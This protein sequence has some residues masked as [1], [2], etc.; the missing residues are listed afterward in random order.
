MQ[1]TVMIKENSLS[2]HECFALRMTIPINNVQVYLQ[3]NDVTTQRAPGLV[4][5]N[6]DFLLGSVLNAVS[7]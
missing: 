7:I 1:I 3:F 5:H 6:V 2:R 4:R